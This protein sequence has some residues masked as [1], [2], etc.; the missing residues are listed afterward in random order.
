M[1]VCVGGA[2]PATLPGLATEHGIRTVPLDVRLGEW[3]PD[4][5]RGI[6]PAEFWRRCATTSA[7]PETFSPLRPG[8]FAESFVQAAE[9]R[10]FGGCLSLDS[11]V[12]SLGHLPCR[13]PRRGR[14]PRAG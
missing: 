4:E 5:M 12:G 7:L 8:A 11:L 2:T 1:A 10:V 9:G 13:L 6:E 14:G 3:G